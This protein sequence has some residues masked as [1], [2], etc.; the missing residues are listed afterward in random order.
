M[1]GLAEGVC[2]TWIL[3]LFNAYTLMSLNEPLSPAA[4][5]DTFGAL[6]PKLALAHTEG[7]NM[8]HYLPS[9]SRSIH[10]TVTSGGQ[11]ILQQGAATR[12]TIDSF[13]ERLE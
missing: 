12:S 4:H 2:A 3:N 6:L 1:Q 13:C 5:F 9:A 11:P 7:L 10:V 8:G